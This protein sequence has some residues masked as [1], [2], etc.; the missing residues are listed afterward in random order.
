MPSPVAWQT[1]GV[2]D[3]MESN[4]DRY[5][6]LQ[7]ASGALFWLPTSLLYFIDRFGLGGA[8]RLQAV[9]YLAVVALEVPSG[10]FS[11]RVGRVATLRISAVCWVAAH[12][13]FLSA[14]SFVGVSTAQVFVAAGF[15]F[16]SG[17]DVTFHYDTLES[18][19][20]AVEFTDRESVIRRYNLV[21]LAAATLVGGALGVVDL[22]LP[23]AASLAAAVFQLVITMGLVE[24]P[25]QRP[26]TGAVRQF[27]AVLG[28]LRQRILVWVAFYVVGEVVTVHLTSELAAP[29][30]AELLGES[31][32]QINRAPLA[33]GVLAAVVAIV[34]A[35]VV[36]WVGPAARRFGPVAVFVVVAAIP[37][38]TISAMALAASVFVLPLI[39]LRSVQTATASVLVP[40]TVA[41]RVERQHRATFLSLTSLAGRLGYGS[42]LLALGTLV[43]LGATLRWASVIAVAT[44]VAVAGSSRL[45]AGAVAD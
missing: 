30:L 38:V 40:A 43:D 23:F 17:T 29:Y 3:A 22:R 16:A 19:G 36:R 7:V 12:V 6:R 42:V 15:A 44:F 35:T 25:W 4:L 2:P 8:L 32:D 14:G 37:M 41:P 26:S 10:W 9:Y 5:G 33:N 18:L 31:L 11:D 20:R 21:A 24:P 34:G 1:A 27:V 39:V 45:V 13:I 28:N